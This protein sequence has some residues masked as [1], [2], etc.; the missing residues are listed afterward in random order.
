LRSLAR[1]QLVVI[2][3]LSR[4]ALLQKL[5]LSFN[6]IAKVDGLSGLARLRHLDL[7]ANAIEVR[8]TKRRLK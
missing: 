5:D 1:N 4:C 2:Q 3:G 7:R 6:R 8:E